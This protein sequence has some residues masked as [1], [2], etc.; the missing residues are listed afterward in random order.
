MCILQKIRLGHR[1]TQ[2]KEKKHKKEK[3][4]MALQMP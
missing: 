4:Y 1:H 2:G 3:N